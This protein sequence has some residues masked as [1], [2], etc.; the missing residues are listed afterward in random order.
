VEKERYISSFLSYVI[1]IYMCTHT[2]DIRA[3]SRLDYLMKRKTC[4]EDKRESGVGG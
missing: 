2:Q 3:E 1:K 4:E